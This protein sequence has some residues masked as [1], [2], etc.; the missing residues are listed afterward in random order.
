MDHGTQYLSDHVLNQLR[1]WGITPSLAFVEQPQTDAV[2]ERFIRTLKE[3]VIH[4]RVYQTLEE[5]RQAVAAFVKRYNE[6]WRVEKLDFLTP[7]EAR[8]QRGQRNEKRRGRQTGV[9][10]TG[11]G[12]DVDFSRSTQIA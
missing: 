4:G 2:S 11:R 7:R 9:Q 1:F 6:Q 10:A 12:T 3:Q 5:V 8:G